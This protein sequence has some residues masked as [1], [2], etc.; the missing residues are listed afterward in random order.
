M[1]WK[2]VSSVVTILVLLVI[3]WLDYLTGQELLFSV[4]YFLPLAWIGWQRNSLFT[5]ICCVLATLIW[6]QADQMAGHV[7]SKEFITYWNALIRL[8]SFLTIAF[9][10]LR[11][12]LDFDRQRVLNNELVQAMAEIKRLSGLLPICASCKK[13]KDPQGQWQPI[14]EYIHAHSEAEFSHGICPECAR[15]LYP[16]FVKKMELE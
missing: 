9:T 16:D 7:Y 5:F 14:E 8:A 12:R 6:Y 10:F 4:F 2:V 3:G 13:I 15:R 1:A 11:I